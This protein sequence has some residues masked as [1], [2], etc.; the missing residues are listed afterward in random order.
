MSVVDKQSDRN[1]SINTSVDKV[2]SS[3]NA[4]S[5]RDSAR[6]QLEPYSERLGSVIADAR[7]YKS[8]IGGPELIDVNVNNSKPIVNLKKEMGVI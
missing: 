3:H 4:I 8:H 5:I 6:D 7:K 2:S 1:S